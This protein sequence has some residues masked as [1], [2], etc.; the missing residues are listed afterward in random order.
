M[1][2][3]SKAEKRRIGRPSAP[4]WEL[5]ILAYNA[6]KNEV[7]VVECKSYLDSPGVRFLA[8]ARADHRRSD[9]YKLFNDTTLRGVIVRRLVRQLTESQLCRKGPAIR[10]CLAAG[11]VVSESDRRSISK[12]FRKRGW[13]LFD[14]AWIQDSLAKAAARGYEDDLSSVVA[15]LLLRTESRR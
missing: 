2:E 13:R 12:H 1:V 6:A 14:E 9:R 15:K 7:L 8:L 11:H 10:M 4:R 5:D 3:L